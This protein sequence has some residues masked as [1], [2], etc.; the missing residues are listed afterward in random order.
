M[1]GNMGRRQYIVG[2]HTANLVID[3]QHR[4]LRQGMRAP[5]TGPTVTAGS[6]SNVQI[7]YHGSMTR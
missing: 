7:G 6:G 5:V 3:E 4:C 1:G 2:G